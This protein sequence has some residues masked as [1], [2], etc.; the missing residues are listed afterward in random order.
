M[1][2]EET[3][4]DGITI[5]NTI[6]EEEDLSTKAQRDVWLNICELCEYF[7][8]KGCLKCGCISESKMEYSDSSCP[9]NK[10]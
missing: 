1:K 2:I 6:Y 7:K 8:N 5:R 3:T 4:V 9:I 10:W